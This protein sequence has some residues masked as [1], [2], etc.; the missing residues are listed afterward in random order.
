METKQRADLLKDEY[1][2]LQQFYEDIDNKGLTIKSWAITVALAAIGAGIVEKNDLI[3]WA[4]LAASIM[5]WYLEAHWRGLSYFFSARIQNIEQIF[6]G[7]ELAAEI[8]LQVYTTWEAEYQ[9]VGDRTLRYM[10]K[11]FTIFPHLIIAG[12]IVVLLIL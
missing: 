4:G 8:P 12:V 1:I 10:F 9:K 3:L 6:Q 2:M 11:P 7:E 5:F